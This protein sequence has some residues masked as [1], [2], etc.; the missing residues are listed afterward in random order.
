MADLVN[1]Q[2]I[3]TY[4]QNSAKHMTQMMRDQF[5]LLASGD[6]TKFDTQFA[7]AWARCCVD[8]AL[9]VLMSYSKMERKEAVDFLQK[10]LTESPE[11][12]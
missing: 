6:V 3:I 5:S 2:M 7:K 4:M 11:K 10:F 12:N 1:L 8:Q 9:F